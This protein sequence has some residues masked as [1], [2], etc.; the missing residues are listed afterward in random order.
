MSV[1]LRGVWAQHPE[2]NSMSEE[3]RAG[4]GVVKLAAIVALTALMV[5]SNYV[6]TYEKKLERTLKV[7]DLRHN[8]N[9]QV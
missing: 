7:S 4:R 6:R 3:E 9:V 5:E 2:D 1:L 8:G